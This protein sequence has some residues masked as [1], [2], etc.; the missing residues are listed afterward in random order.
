MYVVSATNLRQDDPYMDMNSIFS[1]TSSL[2]GSTPGGAWKHAFLKNVVDVLLV[3]VGQRRSVTMRVR[4][5]VHEVSHKATQIP[6]V[7]VERSRVPTIDTTVIGIVGNKTLVDVRFNVDI[8]HTKLL[9]SSSWSFHL[10]FPPLF[11]FITLFSSQTRTDY[12]CA[13]IEEDPTAMAM[14]ISSISFTLS[15]PQGPKDPYI[16]VNSKVVDIPSRSPGYLKIGSS[17]DTDYSC[18]IDNGK[19]KYEVNVK[20]PPVSLESYLSHYRSC[21]VAD[22]TLQIMDVSGSRTYDLS[23]TDQEVVTNLRKLGIIKSGDRII[24][25]NTDHSLLAVGNRETISSCGSFYVIPSFDDNID[26]YIRLESQEGSHVVSFDNTESFVEYRSVKYG[27]GESFMIGSRVVEVVKGS[28]ILVVFNDA[29]L[30]FPGGSSTASQV[31]TSGD[32]I[33]RDLIL[34]SSN[35]VT[36]K[37]S[38]ET[39]YGTSSY[40]VYDS[41][42]ENTLE[43][44]RVRHGLDDS[45]EIGSMSFNVLYTPSS[46]AQV[47]HEAMEI[48][49]T[50]TRIS[51]IN[52]TG[53]LDATFDSSGLRFNSD[54]GDVYFG[55]NQEFRIHYEPASG[56]DPSMLQIQGY[57]SDTAS[58]VTRQLITNEPVG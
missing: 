3:D 43:V 58:Y 57:S 46:G 37:I 53:S 18:I 31:I 16:T 22:D 33:L 56:N 51:T 19:K 1:D 25:K 55:A 52:D 45:G 39:T 41:I 8:S 10:S 23:T 42:N 12:L 34:K 54:S 35:Q 2:P 6:D 44:T 4:G 36:T 32:M 21:R 11:K 14:E 26:Q 29:P 15:W 38:G 24:L 48:D 47:M 9:D 17:P 20:T 30:E 7:F 27:H 49:P 5:Y 50:E 28:I 40:F 13:L